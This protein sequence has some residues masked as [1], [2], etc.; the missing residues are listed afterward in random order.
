MFFQRPLGTALASAAVAIGAE[1][2]AR[3]FRNSCGQPR[4][5]ADGSR[6]RNTRRAGFSRVR[7]RALPPALVIGRNLRRSIQSLCSL[8]ESPGRVARRTDRETR[9]WASREAPEN[10][11]DGESKVLGPLRR[12]LRRRKRRARRAG[13]ERSNDVASAGNARVEDRRASASFTPLASPSGAAPLVGGGGEPLQHPDGAGGVATH[14]SGFP[15]EIEPKRR[16]DGGGY[17]C[18]APSAQRTCR[19]A[20]VP[21]R[22]LHSAERPQGQLDGTSCMPIRPHRRQPT[23]STQTLGGTTVSRSC[24]SIEGRLQPSKARPLEQ[25]SIDPGGTMPCFCALFRT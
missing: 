5:P 3:S 13:R 6:A 14:A 4:C 8:R 15:R 9:T 21:Y 1:A 12:A 25:G 24:G 19:S 16:V 11:G 20:K 10:P 17:R 18:F 7:A 23:H 22:V 2:R